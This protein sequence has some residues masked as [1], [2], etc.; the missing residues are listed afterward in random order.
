MGKRW[1]GIAKK[2][3]ERYNRK[4][5]ADGEDR[6]HEKGRDHHKCTGAL[7]GRFF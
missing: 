4:E 1:A 7:P 2:T 3:Q 5:I 6:F